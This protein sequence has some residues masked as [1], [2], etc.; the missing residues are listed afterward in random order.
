MDIAPYPQ[1]R[2]GAQGV[3]EPE[4]L[5]FSG[6]VFK[7]QANM[8]PTHRDRI[9][10]L[11]VCS[12]HFK[13][14]MAVHHV[15]MGKTIKLSQPQQFFAQDREIIEEAYPGDI[16][17]LYDPGIFKIGDTLSQGESFSF[18]E[19]PQFAPENFSKVTVKDA[20][21]YKQFNK[22][23]EQLTEEGAIQVF[24]T[25]GT[26]MDEMIL[27]AV[28]VLQFEVFEYRLK[29][30]YG[31]DVFLQKLPY[32]YARWISGSKSQIEKFVSGGNVIVTD[33]E[34]KLVALFQ[35]EFGLRW[36]KEKYPDVYFVDSPLKL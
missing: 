12:G 13:R 32:E 17:G 34:K 22:G 21:K 23:V 15:R 16:I 30:E 19:M 26:G 24:K 14:G 27:G 33:K 35:N 20:M 1:P 9:A 31:V 18:D 8:N 10:F 5:E 25:F 36:A 3:I 29:A 2:K 4:R 6:Y 11:R 7:I 28:G